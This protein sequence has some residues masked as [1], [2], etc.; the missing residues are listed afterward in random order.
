MRVLLNLTKNNKQVEAL[1]K[2]SDRKNEEIVMILDWWSQV[3][4]KNEKKKASTD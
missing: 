1:M 4:F 3:R 2:S